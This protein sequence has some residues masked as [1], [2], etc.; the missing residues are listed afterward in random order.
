MLQL[1][2][3]QDDDP[4][5]IDITHHPLKNLKKCEALSYEW[6]EDERDQDIFCEGAVIKG[7]PNLLAVLKRLRH[8]A[9]EARD[10]ETKFLWI[11]AICIDQDDQDD[12]KEQLPLMRDIYKNSKRC[13]IWI[14]EE[15]ELSREAFEII[16][17]LDQTARG[18]EALENWGFIVEDTLMLGNGIQLQQLPSHP[19]WLGVLDILTSRSYFARLWTVQEVA[20]SN[21]N[22]SQVLCGRM[23]C[24]WLAFYH[25]VRV[26]ICCNVLHQ[27]IDVDNL[28]FT[29]IVENLRALQRALSRKDLSLMNCVGSTEDQRCRLSHDRVFALLGMLSEKTQR[30]LQ[31]L[32]Y[33]K[34]E[35]EIF[36]VATIVMV[37]E[38]QDLWY[39]TW[40]DVVLDV[41]EVASWVGFSEFE[42]QHRFPR[43]LREIDFRLK[44]PITFEVGND[45]VT[46][47]NITK[48][49]PISFSVSSTPKS[50]K[51]DHPILVT[52]GFFF[53]EVT[54]SLL[55]FR[56]GNFREHI[57]AAYSEFRNHPSTSFHN[58]G[59]LLEVLLILLS[60]CGDALEM[61]D[62]GDLQNFISCFSRWILEDFKVTSEIIEKNIALGEAGEQHQMITT[63]LQEGSPHNWMNFKQEDLQFFLEKAII[64]NDEEV[65][66][67][68]EFFQLY[69][70]EGEVVKHFGRNIFFSERG[71]IGIGPMGDNRVG[72]PPAVRVGDKIMILADCWMPVILRLREDGFYTFVGQAHLPG[73]LEDSIFQPGNL[74]ELE[75]IRIR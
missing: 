61:E 30:S 49:V 53:D 2:P 38:A 60:L 23:S 63:N 17:L 44:N 1:H 35:Q 72:K 40:R 13:L 59:E 41:S 12:K 15:P 4:I 34:P 7:T 26:V 8:R 45:I 56:P 70:E 36:Q 3:G 14:G 57:L 29:Y 71:H 48:G 58:T 73:L 39:F 33:D 65:K 21:P 52:E 55:N 67:L 74:P 19:A 27:T 31:L 24:S 11:D 69:I 43:P 37:L 68:L 20:L 75:D 62:R 9:M 28:D 46:R 66:G 16:S 54:T 50:S 18:L 22:E 6:G 10:S 51:N 47:E 32:D 5:Q 42:P 64:G 25:A